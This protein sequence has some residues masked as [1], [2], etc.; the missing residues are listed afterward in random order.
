MFYIYFLQSVKDKG[1][2]IGRTNNL[3]RR[4]IEHNSG[5]VSCTKSRRPFVLLGCKTCENLSQAIELEKEW[6]K[7]Y[8]REE[9]KIKYNIK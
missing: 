7:G 9:L 4:F 6:K 8:K 1:L 5:C 2:Y 3:K